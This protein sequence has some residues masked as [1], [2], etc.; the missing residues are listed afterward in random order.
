[1]LGR[2]DYGRATGLLWIEDKMKFHIAE[3]VNAP[4]SVAREQRHLNFIY[5]PAL[6]AVFRAGSPMDEYLAISYG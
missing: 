5:R 3:K 4:A 1:M 6:R 2:H